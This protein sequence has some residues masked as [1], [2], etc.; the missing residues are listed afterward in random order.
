MVDD[1]DTPYTWEILE[2]LFHKALAMA[3][4]QR[5][6][7]LARRCKGSPS[8]LAEVEA[9]LAADELDATEGIVEGA[10]GDGLQ[11]VRADPKEKERVGAS[12]GSYR[13]LREVGR[14]GTST[15]FLAERSDGRF[16]KSVAVKVPHRGP[17]AEELLSRFETERRILAGLDHP[18]IARLLDAGTAEDGQPFFVMEF[19]EGEPLDRY[20]EDRDLSIEERLKLFRTICGAV[21]FAHRNLVIHRDLKPG[22][23]LV[24]PDGEPKLLDFGIAKL[25]ASDGEPRF[26]VTRT[27]LRPM[28]PRY[29]SPEQ[30]AGGPL[31]TATDVYS[32]GVVLYRLLAGE[33]PQDAAC[34]PAEL[35]RQIREVRPKR[36]SERLTGRRRRLLEGDLDNIVLMALAKDP[37]GRYTSAEQL[38]EDLRRYLEGQPVRARRPTFAY[39]SGKFLRRHRVG[40]VMTLAV[41]ALI[42]AFGVSTQVQ[43]RRTALEAAKAARTLEFLTEMFELSEPARSLGRTITAREILDRGAERIIDEFADQPEVQAELLATVGRVYSRLA[44]FEDARPLLEQA[45]SLRRASGSTPDLAQS[46]QDLA[47]LHS[48]TGQ[49]GAAESLYREA[50]DQR[51]SFFGE[52]HPTVVT[53]LNQLA[54]GLFDLGRYQEAE[55]LYLQ[56]LELGEGLFGEEHAQVA[57]TVN[58]LAVLYHEMGDLQRAEPLYRRALE[59]RRRLLGPRHPDLVTSLNNLAV[60]KR[61]QGDLEEA[62]DLSRE[63]VAMA[64]QLYGDEPFPL[65]GSL[66]ILARLQRDRGDFAGAEATLREVLDIQEKQHVGEHSELGTTLHDLGRV[67]E[68]KGDLRAAQGFFHRALGVY[69]TTLPQGHPWTAF[70]LLALGRVLTEEGQAQTAEPWLREALAVREKGLPDSRWRI[71]E[72]ESALGHCLAAQGRR[73]EALPLLESGYR[74][75]RE[76]LG[77]EHATTHRARRYLALAKTPGGDP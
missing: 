71:G 69:R 59:S 22:N 46:L 4:E 54:G 8:L 43:H 33:Y 55:P 56:A 57:T 63:A 53:S 28:T 21:Q 61:Q 60:I 9:L 77:D 36:P 38:S 23:I 1:C 11:R 10:V 66:K 24:T 25:F 17:G 39:R 18:H 35:E 29:A 51:R 3:S 5:P 73:E 16:E 48:Q 15:V 41:A 34:G 7:F 52:R 75:L 67:M 44:L 27:G 76:A 32:L 40:A 64:R 62:E 70:P 49:L 42:V 68:Q 58:D 26:E 20:C 72:V 31:T 6:V 12:L 14:G 65:A 2:E 13:I 19:V 74:S 45:L 47:D 37:E 50:L 30:V